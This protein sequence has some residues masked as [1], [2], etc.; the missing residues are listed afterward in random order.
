[1]QKELSELKSKMA[2]KDAVLATYTRAAIAPPGGLPGATQNAVF[3]AIFG[4]GKDPQTGK[5]YEKVHQRD[6]KL[7]GMPSNADA[8]TSKSHPVHS[9]AMPPAL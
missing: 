2:D 1:M 9:Y 3:T 4:F 7:D 5:P 6:A 8:F